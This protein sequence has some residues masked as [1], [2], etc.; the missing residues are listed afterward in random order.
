MFFSTKSSA[1]MNRNRTPASVAIII[2]RCSISSF[3]N[4]VHPFIVGLPP[5][6][7]TFLACVCFDPGRNS[8]SIRTSSGSPSANSSRLS[9]CAPIFLYWRL[10]HVSISCQGFLM[11]KQKKKVTQKA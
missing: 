8:S 9:R 11:R 2:A 1:E 4:A 10:A 6:A 5:F 3:L 7:A